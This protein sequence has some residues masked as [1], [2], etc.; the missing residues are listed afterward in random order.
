[1]ETIELTLEQHLEELV[2]KQNIAMSNLHTIQFQNPPTNAC[3][4]SA[5][6]HNTYNIDMSTRTID[7]P[8]YL[9]VAKDHK[10]TVIYFKIDR[11]FEF[12]DLSNTIC[13]IEYIVPNSD[14]KVPYLYVVPYLDIMTYAT[15]GKMVFPWVIGG[16]ATQQDGIIEYDIRFYKLESLTKENSKIIYDLHTLP[17]QSKVLTGLGVE[18]EDLKYEYD[19]D[20]SYVDNLIGQIYSNITCWH[21]LG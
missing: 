11:Y 8:Q 20:A 21:T 2:A 5:T 1:M 19:F 4:P 3:L 9:S 17:A 14:K 18:D 15:E 12:M 6:A 10:S 16:I 13:V 7:A